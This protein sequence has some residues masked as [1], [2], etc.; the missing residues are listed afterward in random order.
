MEEVIRADDARNFG[1]DGSGVRVAVIDTGFSYNEQIYHTTHGF[2][3][4]YEE[5][6]SDLLVN[7]FTGHNVDGFDWRSDSVG[8]GTA[9]V[10]NLLAVAPGIHLDFFKLDASHPENSFQAALA[11]NPDVISCS[12]GYIMGSPD[13]NPVLLSLIRQAV[14]NGIIV[15]FAVGNHV[16]GEQDGPNWPGTD[17]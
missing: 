2:H 6:Y 1:L 10:S 14:A 15:V 17:P 13:W 7:R 3:P 5:Y 4:Y 11:V 16:P 12:W 9:I 8:H